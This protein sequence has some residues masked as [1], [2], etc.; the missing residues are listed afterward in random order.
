[1]FVPGIS[2]LDITNLVY[3]NATTTY[4]RGIIS[5]TAI[6]I[7]SFSVPYFLLNSLNTTTKKRGKLHFP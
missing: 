7:V 4:I 2:H 6:A 5:S 3:Y 1:M